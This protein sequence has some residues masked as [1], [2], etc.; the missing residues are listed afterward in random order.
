[1]KKDISTS[2]Q[3]EFMRLERELAS[4][5]DVLNRKKARME[6]IVTML[7]Q[8]QRLRDIHEAQFNRAKAG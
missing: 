2:L 3:A 4:D 7:Q 8:E 6:R 1:M 5:I